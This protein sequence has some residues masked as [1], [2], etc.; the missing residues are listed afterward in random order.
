MLHYRFSTEVTLANEK[1]RA[2]KKSSLRH[3]N[4]PDAQLPEH[5]LTLQ[6]LNTDDRRRNRRKCGG[7]RKLLGFSGCCCYGATQMSVTLTVRK[8]PPFRALRWNPKSQISRRR[9]KCS[10]GCEPVH[11]ARGGAAAV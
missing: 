8:L 9:Q 7:R 11:M 6:Y 4:Q 2:F 3:A 5:A 1:S 10:C